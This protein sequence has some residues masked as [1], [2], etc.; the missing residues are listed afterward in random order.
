[1][2]PH[3]LLL[4][5]ILAPGTPLAAPAYTITDLGTLGGSFSEGR[6]INASGQ[7][8]G[9]SSTADGGTGAFLWDGISMFNLNDLIAPGSGWILGQGLAIN[10]AGQITG[11]GTIGDESH[12]F[13]L[14][15]VTVV[16]VPE[17]GCWR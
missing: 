11:S 14:T 10:D 1:M 2:R 6:G 8:T 12:A 5:G 7:V 9:W 15:P 13:L 17:P 4:L 16:E 3:H